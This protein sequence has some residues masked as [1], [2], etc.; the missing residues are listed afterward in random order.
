MEQELE[1][2][3]SA[4]KEEIDSADTPERLEDLRVQYVGRSGALSTILRSLKDLP[5]EKRRAIGK[6]ANELRREVE[7]LLKEKR[8]E[9]EHRTGEN[10][11]RRERLD[12][13]RPGTRLPK[14]HLHPLTLILRDV[15]A[16][17]SSLGFE[18]ADGPEVEDEYHNFDA[19]NIPQGHPAREMWDTFWIRGPGDKEKSR[20]P[21]KTGVKTKSSR[22]LLRT[23]TSPVQIRYMETHNPPIRIIAPG[24]VF[25]Y[26]ATDASHDIQFYQLE[27]LV[28]ERNMSIA[29]FK[30]VIAAFFSKLFGKEISVRLRPSYFPFVEPGF[31][32]DISCLACGGSGCSVCKKSGWLEL[33]GAG[34][35]H[36]NVFKAVGY[37]PKDMQGF[38]FG[39]GVD[40][41]AMMKYKIPDIR[42]FHSGD[43]RFLEQF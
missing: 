30:A 37:N 43:I 17:F 12:V 18:I 38:A 22:L 32:V 24:R 39:M 41:L 36:P 23:H 6:E 34:M 11:W 40:R 21:N 42:L 16:I 26:E 29:N 27:G 31:E 13:T 35:V 10:V 2:I 8:R 19:L 4:A 28:V 25:R 14:G 20:S 5:G 1:K 33:A 7:N 3:R 9:V 15:A